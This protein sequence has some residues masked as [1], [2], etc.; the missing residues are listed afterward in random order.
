MLGNLAASKVAKIAALCVCPVGAA[1]VTTQVPQV[2]SAVHRM[3]A[4]KHVPARRLAPRGPETALASP[5]PTA[6]PVVL[7]QPDPMAVAMPTFTDSQFNQTILPGAGSLPGQTPFTRIDIGPG[8][9]GGD[10]TTPG[11]PS[12]LPEPASWAQFGIGFALLGSAI[13]AP[14]IRARLANAKAARTA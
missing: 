13:R 1:V 14:K 3:T 7:R 10:S 6:I 4:P 11:G 9:G 8:G 2:R 5:C 12:V